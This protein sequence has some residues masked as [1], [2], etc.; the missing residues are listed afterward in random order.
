VRIGI[1]II[2]GGDANGVSGNFAKN[3]FE[4]RPHPRP[5]ADDAKTNRLGR[6]MGHPA[7]ISHFGGIKPSLSRLRLSPNFSRDWRFVAI[8]AKKNN[9]K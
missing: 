6:G 4:N 1:G 2:R 9:E 7:L 5:R 3:V 8:P